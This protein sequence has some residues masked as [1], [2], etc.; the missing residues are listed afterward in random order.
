[1][2]SGP[3]VIADPMKRK[4]AKQGPQT[5][6]KLASNPASQLERTTPSSP[7]RPLG[8]PTVR[9]AAPS[10]PVLDSSPWGRGSL[11]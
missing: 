9:S 7:S 3:P 6:E 2:G 10:V 11:L 1:M 4:I 8:P 5:F